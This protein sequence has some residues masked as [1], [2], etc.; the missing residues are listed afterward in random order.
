MGA[1]NEIDQDKF[2]RILKIIPPESGNQN[3]EWQSPWDLM[4]SRMIGPN[5]EKLLISLESYL[6]SRLENDT[7]TS[8]TI[9]SEY[10]N[11]LSHT[12]NNLFSFQGCWRALSSSGYEA[13][14]C[15]HTVVWSNTTTLNIPRS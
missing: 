9:L 13:G 14:V 2:A 12:F 6:K 15:N 4:E 5:Q 8:N 1:L 10:E 3:D 7:V 11:L